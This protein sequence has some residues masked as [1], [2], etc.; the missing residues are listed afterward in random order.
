M[1]R[2]YVEHGGVVRGAACHTHL[3][4]LLRDI[5]ASRPEVL[6]EIK[7]RSR[8]ETFDDKCECRRPGAFY[9]RVV[10]DGEKSSSGRRS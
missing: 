2:Q 5:M 1:P 7:K 3:G 9:V 8:A 6:V 10:S 4:M